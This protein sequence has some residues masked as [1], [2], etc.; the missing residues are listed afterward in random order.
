MFS[1]F[2]LFKNITQT[3]QPR[4]VQALGGR[5][6]G[7][8]GQA[9]DVLPA[10]LEKRDEIVD[11][12]HDV[13]E[14]LLNLH[15]D[16]A[17]SD[18]H[19]EDLLELELDGALD[20]GDLAGEVIRVGDGG[21]ELAGLGETGAEETGDLLNEGLGGDEGVVLAG[22]LLDE[23]L[24]LVELLQVVGG[25]GVDTAVLGTV[26]IMLVT[27]NADGHVGAGNGG[28]LDGAG[29]TLITLGIV[30]LEA[31]LELDGLEEVTLLGL[32]GVLQ[33]IRDLRPDISCSTVS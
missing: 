10:L 33:E 25:H 7:L 2:F 21:G 16:V 6:G 14:E 23:L 12:K 31:D 19:A 29:E 17:N 26:E 30:V 15:L 18:T 28:Q 27:E 24:V 13:A 32:V 20:L 22:E 11:G 1:L 4:L 3:K 8:D 5:H 9:A